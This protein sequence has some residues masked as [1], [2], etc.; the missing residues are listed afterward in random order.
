MFQPLSPTA[1][2]SGSLLVLGLGGLLVAVLFGGCQ[3]H[4]GAERVVVSGKVSYQGE[5][6]AEG[7]IRFVPMPGSS[8]PMSGALIQDGRYTVSSHGGVPVGTHKVEIEAYR[9]SAAGP[10]NEAV[11]M[12]KAAGRPPQYLPPRYNVKTDLQI[13]IP[14]G[15]PP[16]TKD[17]DLTH[18]R[19][20]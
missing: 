5:P 2:G 9:R 10:D 1:P 8:V 6:V 17:F 11:P 15:S 16:I 13:S 4:Q 12:G 7:R 3:T 19:D 14:S 20:E 18:Q